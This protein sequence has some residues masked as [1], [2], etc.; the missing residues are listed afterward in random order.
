[1][2][3]LSKNCHSERSRGIS[4]GLDK[5]RR[6]RVTGQAR[7]DKLAFLLILG[8]SEEKV[9]KQNKKLIGYSGKE[10]EL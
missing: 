3:R 1:M 10:I 8:Q 5:P 2:F 7:D 9:T 6:S 4:F